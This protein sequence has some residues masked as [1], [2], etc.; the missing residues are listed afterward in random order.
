MKAHKGT[1]KIR[2]GIIGCGRVATGY[3]LPCYMKLDGVVVSS[4]CDSNKDRL[5]SASKKFRVKS[6]Y[7]NVDEFLEKQNLD[8]VDIC[9][10]GFTHYTIC[11]KAMEKGIGSILVEKPLTLNL[12]ET[13]DLQ[14]L[15][16][17]RNVRVCVV[18]NYRFR[19]PVLKLFEMYTRGKIGDVMSVVSIVHGLSA[20]KSYDWRRD[21]SKSGGLLYE[22]GI[23]AMYLQVLLCGNHKRVIS[24]HNIYDEGLKYTTNIHAMIEYENGAI[25]IID[26]GAFTSSTASHFY[27]FGTAAD[28][29]IKF[30]PD[31]FCTTTGSLSFYKEF[32]GENKR[33]WNFVKTI[34]TGGLSSHNISYHY[35]II[36][37]FINSII[38]D[39]N[40][41]VSIRDVLPTMRLLEDLKKTLHMKTIKSLRR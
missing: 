34:L 35:P 30:Q 19:K 32:L 29:H 40:P 6:L 5:V 22:S 10:P 39:S 12:D 4:L 36:S 9:T 16:E 31:Y 33:F 7:T 23:H 37:R 27:V 14:R 2:V 1:K 17:Q 18:H 25:G 41:P 11:K 8:L 28:V 3:H 38:A 24:A 15:S 21:E 20:F 13:L 26:L